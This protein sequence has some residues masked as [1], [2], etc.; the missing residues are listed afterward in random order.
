MPKITGMTNADIS[1][2]RLNF[3]LKK[4]LVANQLNKA[5]DA[6]ITDDPLQLDDKTV[7]TIHKIELAKITFALDQISTNFNLKIQINR[8]SFLSEVDARA[9]LNLD[10]ATKYSID[11]D[12]K[13]TS[14][15]HLSD[16]Q[17]LE[18]PTLKIGLIQLSSSKIAGFILNRIKPRIEKQ[19]DQT[20]I[21][22]LD[23][24]TRIK[25]I[26]SI[27]ESP[28]KL[29]SLI[30]SE[31]RLRLEEIRLYSLF[32]QDNDIHGAIKIH[33][34]LQLFPAGKENLTVN[35][36]LPFGIIKEEISNG[37]S[38]I[39]LPVIISYKNIEYWY[40]KKFRN[41]KFE[42]GDKFLIVKELKLFKVEHRIRLDLRV[43]GSVNGIVEILA[44]PKL[45]IEKQ[46]IYFDDIEIK[47]RT[48]NIIHKTASWL[49]REK[50]HE[51]IS[52][53]SQLSI[54]K[55]SEDIQVPLVQQM[56]NILPA[57]IK[58]KID[59]DSFILNEFIVLNEE[60]KTLLNVRLKLSAD[61]QN[62]DFLNQPNQKI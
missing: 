41:H 25:S 23:H 40:N 51:E 6:F 49:M 18:K 29:D 30:N 12:W 47:L 13:I 33:T 42:F 10:F 34:G 4:D 56:N 7:L 3:S 55:L 31:L 46:L 50:I 27:L 52:R 57:Y 17:W 2:L 8:T 32:E 14:K 37:L 54:S 58:A 21:K 36:S 19:I 22:L 60:I 48:F 59:F 1:I 16:H 15:T 62:L 26:F 11:K 9:A 43:T 24:R 61:I 20:I 35:N 44:M 45:D 38:H 5:L 53:I 39:I 28:I